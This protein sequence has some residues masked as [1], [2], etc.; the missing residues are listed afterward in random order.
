MAAMI[1]SSPAPRFGHRSMSMS[2]TRLSNLDQL[3]R[4]GPAG[5]VSTSQSPTAAASVAAWA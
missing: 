4:C 2:K 1:F 3:I 5:T